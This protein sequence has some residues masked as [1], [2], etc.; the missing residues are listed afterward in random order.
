MNWKAFIFDMD[1]TL[2]D[3]MAF[4]IEIWREFL[5]SLGVKLDEKEFLQRAVGRT[6]ADI[7]R[8]FVNPDLSDEEIRALGK[9]KEAL[10]RSRFRPLMR[11]VPGLTR[12]LARAK[13]KGIRIALATSAG[14][15]NARFVLEGLDIESYFDVLVTGDQ[16]TQG[17]PHPEIFL[18]AAERLSIHPSEGLVFEDS[19]LGLEAAHR[20]GMASIAL[21]TTYPPEHLMT[22]PGV[23]AVVPDYDTLF[24]RDGHLGEFFHS[25]SG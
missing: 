15:E 12:L 14:V 6:N 9:Q 16:V 21:S 11:E 25:F 13:Q 7:L 3:N 20:A 1:G 18:K 22:L 10:Y 24:L 5:H 2:L 4:H 8:D 19:P 23:L 17:K